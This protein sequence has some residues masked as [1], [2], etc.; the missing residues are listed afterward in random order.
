MGKVEIQINHDAVEELL[1]K[2]MPIVEQ[3]AENIARRA[4]RMKGIGVA[5]YEVKIGHGPSPKYKYK[6]GRKFAMV[7]ADQYSTKKDNARNNTLLKAV[8]NG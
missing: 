1:D 2:A 3:K 6:G 7:V 4:N 8:G 5:P